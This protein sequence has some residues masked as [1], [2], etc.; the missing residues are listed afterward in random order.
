MA[1]LR[2]LVDMFGIRPTSRY[3]QDAGV[4][5][6]GGGR[7][8][9]RWVRETVHPRTDSP[10]RVT[11]ARANEQ[12]V[13]A[14]VKGVRYSQV[15]PPSED[16]AA[17]GA[18]P[19]VTLSTG[20]KA[21]GKLGGDTW[22]GTIDTRA[23]AATRDLSKQALRKLMAGSGLSAGNTT[24]K[25]AAFGEF[26]QTSQFGQYR[27]LGMSAW[28]RQWR[29]VN[30]KAAQ[31]FFDDWA[32]TEREIAAEI[33]SQTRNATDQLRI[34]SRNP[35]AALT[36]HDSGAIARK[37][38]RGDPKDPEHYPSFAAR[39]CTIASGGVVIWRNVYAASLNYPAV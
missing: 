1:T 6:P 10:A 28:A 3:L 34:T 13:N 9:E 4:T 33:L 38:Q 19:G 24:W 32:E 23:K 37:L 22:V 7:I 15:H 27:M 39:Y 5:Q 25:L 36:A 12:Y 2:K 29:R 17:S 30:I 26:L 16:V 14:K 18:E 21:R 20:G 11:R 8:N 31:F 35:L